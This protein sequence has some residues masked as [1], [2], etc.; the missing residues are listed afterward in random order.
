MTTSKQSH[1]AQCRYSGT[2]IKTTIGLLKAQQSRQA[3]FYDLVWR[4]D[5][6]AASFTGTQ[7]NLGT[8]AQV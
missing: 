7:I 3:F 4:G 5:F 1:A 8:N 6:S 2:G